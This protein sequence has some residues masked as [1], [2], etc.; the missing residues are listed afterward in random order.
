MG[1][2]VLAAGLGIGP[3]WA[4]GAHLAPAAPVLPAPTLADCDAQDFASTLLPAAAGADAA[5]TA[6]AYFL[7]AFTLQWPHQ[8]TDGRYRLYASARGQ[9]L[10]PAGEAVQGAD[11]AWDLTLAGA[12]APALRERFKFVAPG[13]L[14]QLPEAAR[15]DEA[16]AGLLKS[17]LLLVREDAQGHVLAATAPQA[18]GALDARYVAAADAHLGVSVA[19]PGSRFALW[20]PTAQAAWLCLQPGGEA[21]AR[22]L[23][24]LAWTPRDGVW[25]AT[26]DGD[27]GGQYYRYLVDVFVPGVGLVRNRVTDPYSR[28]LNADSRRSMVIDLDAASSQPHGWMGHRRPPAPQR[29]TDMSLYELHVRDFSI[30]DASVPPAM[31]GKYLAFT[32]L[33]SQGMQHLRLLAQAGLT[34][35]HL[36]PVFDIASIPERNCVTPDAPAHAGPAS[37]AQQAVVV[38]AAAKDCYNW[39]YDP[40]HYSAPE[41]SYAS[42]ADDGAARVREFRA[43]VMALHG[44]GLRVGMDVVYNHTPAAGQQ[45]QSVLDRIVP[46]Y[47]QRLDAQGR[48][49]RSTCCDNTATEHL[50]MG[51]LLVDSVLGWA[52]DFGLDSFRFDLMGHQ[53][54]AVMETLAARLRTQTGHDVPLIGEGWDFGE[55]AHGARFVQASQGSLAGSGIATFSDRA[56][57]ALRGG[58]PGDLSEKG[59]RRPG[60]SNGLG[61]APEGVAQ[62]E[63]RAAVLAAADLVR[64][65][66]AGTLGEFRM[67]AADGR[68]RRLAELPYGDQMA[69]YAAA[70][71]EVVNYAENHDNHTLYDNNVLRL[72]RDT[73]MAERVRV[74][75]LST[76]VVAYSQGI[77]Y[78]HAGMEL[79]RSK[80]LD[81]NSYESGDWFNR[82]DWS[83]HDN[84]FGSGLPPAPD[85]VSAWP[86][87]R[88]LLADPAL[89]PA[90]ADMR[91]ARDMFLDQLRVRRSSA[92]F[93]LD[94]AAAMQ[95]RLHFLNTGPDQNPLLVA[96][97]LD[98]AGLPGAHFRAILLMFNAA[99]TPQSLRL[100][101]TQGQTW[102][103]HPVLAS[104]RSA[105]ARLRECAR[106]DKAS[107]R[108]EVPGRTAAVFVLD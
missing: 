69:G 71:G 45:A 32:Q 31:R 85:N 77:A 73:P 72:P 82:I 99:S 50:M 33:R 39:G 63:D 48:V 57:D 42:D 64:T 47:Y 66:L 40:W 84:T 70:P 105:D 104:S 20:A 35:L 38:A 12:L 96:E 44:M 79:L 94:S 6:E 41:G 3:A 28:S 27:L 29:A 46:G 80:S 90:P 88:D 62:A 14:L 65:G 78:F 8:A 59:L 92:L 37:E 56:R 107:G 17:Q 100:P 49:E 25:R 102:R 5:P 98:G 11:K 81:R 87:Y 51:K 26:V 53:P 91:Q 16:M 76:A 103:L 9:L 89:K 24:P 75:M 30:S 54:R 22:R 1:L 10:A 15:T 101:E 67:Q 97:R 19:K 93:H 55:V 106:F 2:G 52:R 13:V 18:T 7:D 4:Q 95:Q 68:E 43:M 108:F 74:Q 36:M 61:Q 60:W 21:H 23:L 58:T 83:A 86:L 34:D